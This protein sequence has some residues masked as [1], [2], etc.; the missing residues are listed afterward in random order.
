MNKDYNILLSKVVANATE[1]TWAQAFSILNLYIVVSLSQDGIEESI[2][3]YGKEVLEKLQ[4]EFFAIDDKNLSTIK[5]A[6]INTIEIINPETTYSVVLATV[7][8]SVIYIVI[9][10][11]GQVLLK[12][13]EHMG[14]VAKGEAGE[15]AAFS[16]TLENSDI[17]V[18]ESHDLAKKIKAPSY[19]DLLQN[20][21]VTA[22]A[23]SLAPI[24]QSPEAL[25]TEAAVVLFYHK[26][27]SEPEEIS[28]EEPEKQASTAQ[29]PENFVPE[30]LEPENE[31]KDKK[32][33]QITLPSLPLEK[34]RHIPLTKRTLIIAVAIVLIIVLFMGIF[35]ETRKRHNQQSQQNLAA[36]LTPAQQDYDAGVGLET[37]N[38][39]LA[40][41]SLMNAHNLLSNNKNKF[42][43]NSSEQKQ[44]TDLLTKV[45][46][47]I[48]KLGGNPNGQKQAMS[49][50]FDPSASIGSVNLVALA[51]SN[52]VAINKSNGSLAVLNSDGTL[53]QKIDTDT[54][55]IIDATTEEN[56]VYLL[57]SKK[58]VQV[59]TETGDTKTLVT[60]VPN[61][62]KAIQTFTGNVYI[63][64]PAKQDV[65]KYVAPDFDS[66]SY[67]TD[68]VSFDNTPV[69]FAID[70]SVYILESNGKIEKFT[71]G[72]S[73]SFSVNGLSTPFGSNALILT[74][75]DDT[76]IY[77]LD[78]GNGRVVTLQKSGH[79][80]TAYS[81][82]K[83]KSGSSFAIDEVDKKVFVVSDNK[84]YSF[85]L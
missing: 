49:V 68:S 30:E 29:E 40:L 69:S 46:A 21:D 14:V 58:V 2:T 1:T 27:E 50:F 83:I 10:S 32:K 60:D 47:E 38:K 72:K 76:N 78:P 55:N 9:A 17:V 70:S 52:P 36:I 44:I 11:S 73:D 65:R 85:S 26:P 19:K 31:K 64:D 63:L 28:S 80:S 7:I 41:N 54:S 79:Y 74:S 82:D 24:V 5:Q 18:L 48:V 4:R 37:L 61:N 84:L 62:A 34:L 15:V 12:R 23:E 51:Q 16:G 13:G 66:A 25:G 67:F 81:Y 22:I 3:A 39:P 59:N 42:S 53:K 35:M 45:D 20:P 57:T 6:L 8:D 56:F 33:F 77:V 43:N 71:R 75:A